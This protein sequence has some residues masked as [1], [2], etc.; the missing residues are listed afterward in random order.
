MESIKFLNGNS[1]KKPTWSGL[2]CVMKT[3]KNE[4]FNSFFSLS[5]KTHT[6]SICYASNLPL[7]LK[8]MLVKQIRRSGTQKIP[9]CIVPLL[10]LVV[11]LLPFFGGSSHFLQRKLLAHGS[12][13]V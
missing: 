6:K 8:V 3:C 10:I 2:L 7:N 11:S 13:R 1:I 9:N 4:C 12:E 5:K